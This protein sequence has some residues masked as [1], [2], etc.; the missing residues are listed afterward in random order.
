MSGGYRGILSERGAGVLAGILPSIGL[1]L[2][3][4]AVLLGVGMLGKGKANPLLDKDIY[5][6]SAVVLPKADSLPDKATA[7]K[8]ETDPGAKQDAPEPVEDEMVLNVSE[9]EPTPEAT[10]EPK[11]EPTPKAKAPEEPKTPS[12]DELVASVNADESDEVRFETSTE[13]SEDATPSSRWQQYEGRQMTPWERRLQDRIKDN[14]L[15]GSRQGKFVAGS[16]N[17]DSSLRTVVSFK[18]T[19]SGAFASP[20][21]VHRSG[22]AIFDQSCLQAVIRTRR[23]EA[24]PEDPWTVNL[25][26][27]PADKQ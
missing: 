27:D 1:H 17:I 24:P 26:F 11:E 4:V 21:I 14:W 7:P 12:R 19:G 3:M 13:G 6:V 15:P 9:P 18:V 22:D 25:L 16:G 23:F 10:P 5:M 8:P 2:V 20:Q